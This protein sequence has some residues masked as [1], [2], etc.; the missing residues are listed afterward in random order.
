MIIVSIFPVWCLLW[1][2][3]IFISDVNNMI[4]GKYCASGEV[5]R[6]NFYS[7]LHDEFYENRGINVKTR[8][9]VSDAEPKRI[10]K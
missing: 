9:K 4:C 8:P 5:G 6:G 2:L 3:I 10:K 7:Y 1:E